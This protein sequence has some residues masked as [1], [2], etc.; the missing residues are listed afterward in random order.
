VSRR[1][2][3]IEIAEGALLADI[4][5]VFQLIWL[6][7]PLPGLFLRFL[8]PV[9]FTILV[10]RRDL[11]TGL[12]SLAVALFVVGVMTGP[13]L[14]DLAY[15]ALEGIGGLFLGTTMNWRLGHMPI[16]IAGI[17]GLGVASV[18]VVVLTFVIFLPIAE[19]ARTFQRDLTLS[20]AAL[21][22]AASTI[23]LGDQWRHA[24]YPM[25]APLIQFALTYW[26]ALLI[27]SNFAS[28][29]PVVL[30]MYLLTNVLV[31]LLGHDVRPFPGGVVDRLTR[32][33]TRRI[34]RASIRRNIFRRR[35]VSA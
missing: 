8:I 23:G 13:N 12:L 10:L 17:V 26:W 33:I 6:Y 29:V 11:R 1:L 9:V 15:L 24:V 5:V 4:A 16:L 21:G 35:Q 31:R 7:L 34:V 3:P 30:I 28:A 25:L 19:V 2:S 22:S 27:A 14:L 32:R 18:V 20:F